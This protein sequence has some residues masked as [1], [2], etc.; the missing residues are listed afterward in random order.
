MR[1]VCVHGPGALPVEDVPEPTRSI[2]PT[3]RLTDAAAD[4]PSFDARVATKVASQS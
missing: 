1:L 3:V 2:S 4:H